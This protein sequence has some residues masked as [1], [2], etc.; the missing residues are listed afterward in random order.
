MFDPRL[1][2]NACSELRPSEEKIEEMIAMTANHGCK[3][4]IRHPLRMGAVIAAT[5]ALLTIGASAAANP[6]MVASFTMQIASVFQ[7]GELRQDLTTDTGETVTALEIPEARVEDRDGRAILAVMD[8]EI[9]ITDALTEDG[10]YEYK[11]E[12][13]G[14]QLTVLVEGTPE[15]W[16]MT[17]SIRVPG[18]EDTVSAVF[19]K[20][21]QDRGTALTPSHA[22]DV[23][24]DSEQDISAQEAPSV[25]FDGKE[26]A[27]VQTAPNS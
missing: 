5:M 24:A 7:V 25:I 3:K 18:Q 21:E 6:E 14:A 4:K 17:T 13:E 23:P 22:A 11:Y 20:E 12:D 16:T 15:D 8:Q 1:Y 27:A 19:A 9:D 10:R 26:A 2:R